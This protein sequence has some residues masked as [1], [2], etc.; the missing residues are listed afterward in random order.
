VEYPKWI[1][2][3]GWRLR[4]WDIIGRKEGEPVI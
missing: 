2:I 3:I 4:Y 1:K